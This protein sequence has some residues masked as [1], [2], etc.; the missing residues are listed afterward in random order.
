MA[1]TDRAGARIDAEI[2]WGLKNGLMRRY[3]I[4][5]EP[6][7]EITPAGRR[8]LERIDAGMTRDE[9]LAAERRT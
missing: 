8:Y 9:A 1:G 5:G 4:E 2:E 6:G 3:M 7:I